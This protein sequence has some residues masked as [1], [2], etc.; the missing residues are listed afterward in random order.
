M[1][2]YSCYSVY[3]SLWP[4]TKNK[5]HP[6]YLSCVLHQNQTNKQENIKFLYLVHLSFLFHLFCHYCIFC[7]YTKDS[8][9][10]NNPSP[11]QSWNG[12]QAFS[13]NEFS[14][15]D[16]KNLA[17][18]LSTHHQQTNQKTA[19]REQQRSQRL[20]FRLV[21]AR[22]WTHQTQSHAGSWQFCCTCSPVTSYVW[23][24]D[25]LHQAVCHFS[26]SRRKKN[27]PW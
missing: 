4:T 1:L 20:Y 22:K 10:W 27:I 24:V 13:I 5:I 19:I 23:H 15:R 6:R 17:T 8:L 18:Y 12:Q 11:P 7:S 21:Q 9:I 14:L 26:S 25:L 3:K 16:R 2:V